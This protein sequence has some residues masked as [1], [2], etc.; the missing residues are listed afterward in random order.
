L[1]EEYTLSRAY[2]IKNPGRK[3]NNN[4]YLNHPYQYLSGKKI[5]SSSRKVTVGKAVI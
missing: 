3:K 5:P 1:V 4:K 2:I